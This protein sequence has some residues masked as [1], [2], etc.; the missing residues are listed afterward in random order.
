MIFHHKYM[1]CHLSH[2]RTPSYFSWWWN[3]TTNQI[4]INHILT[5]Y[6]TIYLLHPPESFLLGDA[7]HQSKDGLDAPR[8]PSYLPLIPMKNTPESPWFSKASLHIFG[9]FWNHTICFFL[10]NGRWDQPLVSL[11][12]RLENSPYIYMY[13]YIDDVRWFPQLQTSI[14]TNYPLVICYIAMV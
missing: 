11:Q 7:L 13:V 9:T 6:Y 10:V 3:C 2:W 12:R 4:I 5:K 8:I 14:Y 1:G